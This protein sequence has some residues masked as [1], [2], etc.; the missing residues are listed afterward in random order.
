[1]VAYLVVVLYAGANYG[2]DSELAL[3]NKCRCSHCVI[4]GTEQ[5][6]FQLLRQRQISEHPVING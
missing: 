2:V 5:C 3:F 1:V 6:L 4:Y